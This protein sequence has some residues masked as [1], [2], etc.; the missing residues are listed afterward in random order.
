MHGHEG[1][2]V[3]QALLAAVEGDGAR[4]GAE[5]AEEAVGG[6]EEVGGVV[7]EVELLDAD[8]ALGEGA[9]VIATV[10][11]ADDEDD[12]ELAEQVRVEDWAEAACS[13]VVN[14]LPAIRKVGWSGDENQSPREKDVKVGIYGIRVMKAF[15]QVQSLD[16]LAITFPN[17]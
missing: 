2:R 6:P 3:A 11:E 12:V 1:P 10:L 9:A 13:A 7:A 8:T 4:R 14:P 16:A 5:E 15:V 17:T